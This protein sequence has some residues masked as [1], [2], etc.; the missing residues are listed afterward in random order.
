MFVLSN[1]VVLA[2]IDVAATVTLFLS[3]IPTVASS[4]GLLLLAAANAPVLLTM[5]KEC[6]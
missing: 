4:V 3:G 6:R 2:V 1:F 5:L